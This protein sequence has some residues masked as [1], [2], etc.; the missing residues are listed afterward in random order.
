M[1]AIP[2]Y[3]EQVVK[4]STAEIGSILSLA[5]FSSLITLTWSGSMIDK[6]GA[7]PLLVTGFLM[8]AASSYAFILSGDFFAMSVVAVVLGIATGMVNPVQA[9]A[10][11]KGAEPKHEGFYIGFYRIFCD[12]GIILG[13]VIIGALTDYQ[14]F[15]APFLAVSILCILASV[16]A[17]MALEKR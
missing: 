15:H 1:T 8:A 2:L 16:I 3:G 13:P 17:Y 4:L 6:G 10:L 12:I 5:A 11:V 14:G 7:K 9:S